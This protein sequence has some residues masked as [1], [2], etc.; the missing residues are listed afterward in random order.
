MLWLERPSVIPGH[1]VW[2]YRRHVSVTMPLFFFTNSLVSIP[3]I[4][5][6]PV[7][8]ERTEVKG[9]MGGVARRERILRFRGGGFCVTKS[10]IKEVSSSLH[11]W[12]APLMV[13]MATLRLS[14][15]ATRRYF[16]LSLPAIVHPLR[17]AR[18]LARVSS[19]SR[20][21]R[22]SFECMRVW[23]TKSE[24]MNTHSR[25]DMPYKYWRL[26]WE[27]DPLLHS[28]MNRWKCSRY[29]LF[30]EIATR[31]FSTSLHFRVKNSLESKR[32]TKSWITG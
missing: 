5:S 28:L 32:F 2:R 23:L 4:L 20:A 21:D 9:W 18:S 7:E 1:S 12:S 19:F 3:Q 8:L 11:V 31:I 16:P 25:L 17:A 30:C 13:T 24:C 6:A 22:V 27:N 10:A 26:L 15:S 14:C 29:H